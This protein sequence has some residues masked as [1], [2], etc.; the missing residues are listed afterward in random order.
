MLHLRRHEGGLA[1]RD[2]R[3]GQGQEG[4]RLGG[5]CA[6]RT[7]RSAV[8][9]NAGAH[10]RARPGGHGLST[11][12]RPT[13]TRWPRSWAGGRSAERQ[14]VRVHLRLQSR[15]ARRA[16]TAGAASG[17]SLSL[18]AP[19]LRLDPESGELPVLGQAREE[20]RR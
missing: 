19:S 5:R 1:L 13:S 20:G 9:A 10:P 15:F 16:W 2:P 4:R 3:P 6:S 8:S 7:T 17:G 14:A 11:W 12:P 18:L